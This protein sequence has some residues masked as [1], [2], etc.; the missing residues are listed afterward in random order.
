MTDGV[1]V[2]RC[3]RCGW[4]GFP[5]RL[6]C[7]ACGSDRV[8]DALVCTGRVRETTVLRR[9]V[10]GIGGPVRIATVALDGG[11]ILIARLETDAEP[12]A[13]VRLATVSSAP[14]AQSD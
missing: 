3:E 2:G 4:Q 5:R 10:G 9:A 6:W 1:V 13:T 11:G 7:P 8:A 14:T 12:G